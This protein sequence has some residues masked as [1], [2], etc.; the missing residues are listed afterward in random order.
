[1]PDLET[2]RA[3]IRRQ[4]VFSP[5]R[6]YRYTLW[7]EWDAS[8]PYCQFIGL[9]PSTADETNDDPT[10]RRCIAFAKLWGFGALCMTNIFAWRDTDPEKMKRAEDPTGPN[11]D[12]WLMDVAR[13]AG[14]VVAAWGNHGAYILR[15]KRVQL[16]MEDQGVF[17]KCFRKTKTGQ[18]EHPLYQ[19]HNRALEALR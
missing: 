5:C 6:R 16:A 10:I 17:L 1:M 15:G 4:T 3:E 14:V 18:P 12:T 11:N 7:R 19:P 13:G 8:L 9:N 2:L